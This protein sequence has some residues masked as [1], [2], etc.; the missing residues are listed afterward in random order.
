MEA[1]AAADLAAAPVE[2]ASE[3][4]DLEADL[5]VRCAPITDSECRCS[6][7]LGFTDLDSM[8]ADAWA[9]CLEFY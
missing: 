3:A 6:S 1:E 9:V 5:V 8:A 7:A 2:E 4:V